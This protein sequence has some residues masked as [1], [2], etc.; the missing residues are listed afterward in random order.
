MTESLPPISPKEVGKRKLVDLLSGRIFGID[1]SPNVDT[2]CCKA[3]DDVG[4]GDG[5]D[6]GAPRQV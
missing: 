6:G 5:D 2:S 1:Q 4:N 3:H